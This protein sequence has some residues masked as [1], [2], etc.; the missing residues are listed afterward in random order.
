[1]TRRRF[2]IAL[3]GGG[4][5]ELEGITVIGDFLNDHNRIGN[6]AVLFKLSVPGTKGKGIWHRQLFHFLNSLDC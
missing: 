4:F 3:G 1:M 6:Q 2:Y 5:P